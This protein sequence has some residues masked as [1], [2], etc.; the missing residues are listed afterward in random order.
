MNDNVSLSEWLQSHSE[1]KQLQSV[2]LNMDRALK[3]LHEKGYCIEVFH[4]SEISILN[5]NDHYVRFNRIMELPEDLKLRE[6]YIRE[7]IFHS[8]LIQVGT[9]IGDLDKILSGLNKE[10]LGQTEEE[11]QKFRDRFDSYY[12]CLPEDEVSYYRGVIQNNAAVYLCE[13]SLRKRD[14]ELQE[15]K[16]SLGEEASKVY[17]KEIDLANH[18][19][20]D[21]VYGAQI[22]KSTD[23][24]YIHSWLIPILC[25][26]TLVTFGV[27]YWFVHFLK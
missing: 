1:V 13:Y 2:F 16:E 10:T 8:T 14:R 7:D 24:A 15:N 25:F 3:Y 5:Q 4:P 19:V 26:I 17:Q 21:V 12:G 9:Y 22:H 23:G 27:V 6:Q 11:I 20:N 18:S